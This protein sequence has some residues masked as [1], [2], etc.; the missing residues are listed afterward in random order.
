M[1]DAYARGELVGAT[2]EKF[3]SYYLASPARR[4][5]VEF[6][7]AFQIYAE[8]NAAKEINAVASDQPKRLFAGF[9]SSL[10]FFANRNSLPQWS[11]A[12]VALA[13]VILGGFWIFKN[14]SGGEIEIARQNTPTPAN[15][16][17]PK[18]AGET[19]SAIPKVEREVAQANAENNSSPEKKSIQTNKTPVG[20]PP[21]I[22]KQDE[23][24]TLPKISIATFILAPSTRGTN[25]LQNI[26][27]PEK[28]NGVKMRLQMESDDYPTYRVVLKDL[29]DDKIIWQSKTLK[30]KGRDANK[31]LDV[32]FPAKLLKPQIF[33]LQVSGKS[34]DGT[35]EIISDYPFRVER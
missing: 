18:S 26:S 21:R 28:T 35:E 32:I 14:R 1:I 11:F 7:R 33:S 25:Q 12:V 19:S 3:E 16:Q 15:Q 29:S 5:K 34:A 8:E 4:K 13:C 2:L 20:E 22:S 30:S 17:S 6:A 10:N 24:P 31:T 27:L 9:L 23:S